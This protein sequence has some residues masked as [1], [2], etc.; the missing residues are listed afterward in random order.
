M[1]K[2]L[3]NE[4]LSEVYASPNF[5]QVFKSRIIILVGNVAQVGDRTGVCWVLVRKPARDHLD[6]PDIDGRI[7]LRWISRKWYRGVD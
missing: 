6:D 2:R 4:K 7:L 3:R 1:C 5:I